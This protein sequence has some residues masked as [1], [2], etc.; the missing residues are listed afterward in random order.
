MVIDWI[1]FDFW[2]KIA[3]GVI[4]FIVFCIIITL[5]RNYSMEE[6]KK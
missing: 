3:I 2:V 4:G 1:V 5:I 6:T